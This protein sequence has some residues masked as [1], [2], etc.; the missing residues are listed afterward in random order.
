MKVKLTY[1]LIVPVLALSVGLVRVFDNPEAGAV[2][3]V[4]AVALWFWALSADQVAF[5]A[6]RIEA[7]KIEIRKFHAPKNQ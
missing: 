4:L 6:G 5:L 1:R 3:M 2:W 7:Q